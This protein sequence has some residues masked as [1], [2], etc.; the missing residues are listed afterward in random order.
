MRDGWLANGDPGMPD[1]RLVRR[2]VGGPVA[3]AE[4]ISGGLANTNLRIERAGSGDVV[5]LRIYRRDPA[6][7][8][9]E[10]RI[11]EQMPAAVPVPRFLAGPRRDAESGLTYALLEW[12][13][14]ARLERAVPALGAAGQGA[15]GRSLGTV[16]AAVHG[17]TFPHGGFF[18]ADLRPGEALPGGAAG[19]VAFLERSL[20]APPGADR[21]AAADAAEI[22]AFAAAAGDR[23]AAWDERAVLVHG[24]CNGSN[25]LVQGDRVTAL[26]DWEFAFAGSPAFDF[27]NLLRPPAGRHAAFV[28]GLEAGYRDAGGVL[29]A[30]WRRLAAIADLY[31]WADFLARPTAGDRLVQDAVAQMLATARAT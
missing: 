23:L 10:R 19:L 5:L 8:P 27:A 20:G 1:P 30:D 28:D 26:L 7:A 9:K 3:L 12:M 31:A 4:V 2:M 17:V 22:L 24:D 25:V 6:Q 29:P 11:R 15:L 14:G 21:I 16:L 18:D 13:P